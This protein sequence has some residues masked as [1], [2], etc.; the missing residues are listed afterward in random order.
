MGIGKGGVPLLGDN[1]SSLKLAANLVF[2]Q[3]SKHIR[4][5][6]HSLCDC[7]VG[8]IIQLCKIDTRLNA[9]DMLT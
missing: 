1:E 4:T 8:N 7:V 3:R 5:E 2:Y 6:Y 9:A